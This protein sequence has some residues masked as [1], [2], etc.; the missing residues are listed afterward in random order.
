M[1]TRRAVAGDAGS[2]VATSTGLSVKST[3]TLAA[4]RGVAS[5]NGIAAFANTVSSGTAHPSPT[6]TAPANGWLV[7]V[8]TDKSSGTTLWTPPAGV[9]VRGT[10][11]GSA[12][13]RTSALLA[14]SGGP[15]AAG[16]Q[17]GG[18]AT[19]DASSGRA[20]AWTLAL[21]PSP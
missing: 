17:G 19:T 13:G 9:T 8:W 11:F 2:L 12:N 18:V 5:T 20:I 14:D 7:Q 21:T 6:V 4:Y 3:L 15:V 10:S 16:P 1:W